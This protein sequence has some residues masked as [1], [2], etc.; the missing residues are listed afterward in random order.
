MKVFNLFSLFAA[1]C[2]LVFTSCDIEETLDPENEAPQS[3]ELKSPSNESDMVHAENVSFSWN[4]AIDND[5]FIRTYFIYLG[6]ESTPQFLDSVSGDYYNID[7]LKAVTTYYW[8]VEAIDDDGASI[9]SAVQSFTTD[10]PNG[11]PFPVYP[12]DGDVDVSIPITFE[13][14]CKNAL[15]DGCELYISEVGGGDNIMVPDNSAY[16]DLLPKTKYY[17]WVIGIDSSKEQNSEGYYVHGT[18]AEFTTK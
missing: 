10:D 6:T 18:M 16:Y 14:D 8:Q 11:I 2:V 13:W 15:I 17:Y 5:G 3:F 7:S 9:K 1:L 12:A 4:N